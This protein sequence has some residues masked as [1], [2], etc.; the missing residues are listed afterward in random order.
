MWEN[1]AAAI[2]LPVCPF[3]F[4]V[5]LSFS[6]PSNRGAKSSPE[7]NVHP[8]PHYLSDSLFSRLS[9]VVESS[10]FSAQRLCT[11]LFSLCFICLRNLQKKGPRRTNFLVLLVIKV[12]LALSLSLSLSLCASVSQIYLQPLFSLL[13]LVPFCLFHFSRSH[14]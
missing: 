7:A 11:H 13:I 1:L 6:L 5:S 8:E 9:L 10:T 14:E 12:K 2:S 3:A 4:R